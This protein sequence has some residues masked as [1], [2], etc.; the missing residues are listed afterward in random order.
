MTFLL[1]FLEADFYLITLQICKVAA[2]EPKEGEK[3]N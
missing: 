2:E 3:K 1:L